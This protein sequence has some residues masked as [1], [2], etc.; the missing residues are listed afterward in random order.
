MA[1]AAQSVGRSLLTALSVLLAVLFAVDGLTTQ[2]TPV[3]AATSLPAASSTALTERAE[4]EAERRETRRAT[5]AS[6][7]VPVPHPRAGRI[8]AGDAGRPAAG[9]DPARTRAAGHGLGRTAALP[10]PRSG[11]VPIALQVFRC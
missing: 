3:S 2:V 8:R 10:F 7:A 4:E 9:E 5:G 6:T 11:E 1:V